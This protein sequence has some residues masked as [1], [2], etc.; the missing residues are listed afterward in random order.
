MFGGLLVLA[1][2]VV[3]PLAVALAGADALS[4]GTPLIAFGVVRSIP[5]LPFTASV[6]GFLMKNGT[7]PPLLALY[8]FILV[9]T[10][11]HRRVRRWC[12]LPAYLTVQGM[13]ILAG[14]ALGGDLWGAGWNTVA[15]G[16]GV[17]FAAAAWRRVPVVIAEGTGL[18]GSVATLGLLMSLPWPAP[19]AITVAAQPATWVYVIKDDGGSTTALYPDGRLQQVAN[20]R[21]HAHA[22]CPPRRR[23]SARA[24]RPGIPAGDYATPPDPVAARLPPCVCR[25]PHHC[26]SDRP[27]PPLAGRFRRWVTAD[28]DSAAATLRV[29]L[30]AG[31]RGG[32]LSSRGLP[33]LAE[34][35]APAPWL[36]G[37][38]APAPTTG[39]PVRHRAGCQAWW[40]STEIAPPRATPVTGV[41]SRGTGPRSG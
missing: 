13:L 26:A 4:Q 21:V 3:F 2:L 17:E 6:V 38:P 23:F 20:S 15:A 30:G 1:V 29:L 10:S 34:S 7:L 31:R 40:C 9:R 35:D 8:R 25:Q 24:T 28:H 5:V 27:S 41:V 37:A 12:P 33:R 22:V 11:D 36:R 16:F 32:G 14:L 19:Q 39:R 18:L